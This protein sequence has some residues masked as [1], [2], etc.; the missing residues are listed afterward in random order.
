MVFSLDDAADVST[1][2]GTPVT[3]AYKADD[4]HFTGTIGKVTVALK[5]AAATVIADE[6]AKQKAAEKKVVSD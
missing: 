3:E 6:K 1:N 5:E 2:E 4:N